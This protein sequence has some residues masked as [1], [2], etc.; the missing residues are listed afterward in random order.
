MKKIFFL[1]VLLISAQISFGQSESDSTETTE[2]ERK[3]NSL[4][5]QLNTYERLLKQSNQKRK[6]DSLARVD[7]MKRIQLLQENDKVSQTSLRQQIK[8]IERR[9]SLR[10]T[11]QKQRILELRSSTKGYKVEPFGDSLFTIF[12]KLGPVMAED[13]ASNVIEKIEILVRD[14]YFFADSLLMEE[15]EG[16]IDI[17]YK[18]LIVTS[19][20]DWDALWVDGEN[21]NSLASIYQGLISE[22][23]IST[24]NRS[25]VKNIAARIG[26]VFLILGGVLLILYFIRKLSNGVQGWMV[27]NKAKFFTGFKIR[28]FEMLPPSLHL[29]VAIRSISVLKWG[30]Y[31]LVFYLSLPLI[32]G[33]FPFTKGW[34]QTLLDWILSPAKNIWFSFWSYLPNIFTIAV[35]Y[36][37]TSYL[38]KFLKFIAVEIESS[39]LHVP[40]FFP[41]WAMPTYR[42][43][44]FMV[45]AFM[46]VMIYPYLPGSDSDIF[47]GV[48]VFIGLIVSFGSTSAIAN[49]VAGLVI[50]YM[51]PF[52]VGD[53]VKIGDVTGEIVEKSLLVT[54]VRTPK[55]EDITVPNSAILTGHTVNYTSSSRELGLILHTSVTIGYDVPWRKVHELLIEAAVA[56][57]GVNISKEPF[58]LQTSLDDWYVSYQLNAYTDIPEKMPK[59]YS[60]LHANIQDKFNDAGIEIMSPHYRAVRDGN[61]ITIPPK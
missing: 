54:R 27:L 32:F 17:M 36:L 46:I 7:L 57:D 12:T 37:I 35:I 42:L 16:T 58:V 49:A 40:G 38:A 39:R 8:E 30:F 20:S 19:I 48:S 56:T 2:V 61:P 11:Q 13:R 24:R 22:Y 5:Q 31:A 15:H 43:V 21:K 26:L 10:N 9:D 55:N 50:T 41:D 25:T 53:R 28:N 14:D 34:A 29:D 59:T 18:N 60:E 51:R 6:Q 44:K 3:L 52:R 23:V 4:N 33:L 1:L 45:Y 47:K